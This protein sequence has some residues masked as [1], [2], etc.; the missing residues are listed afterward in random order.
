MKIALSCLN[1]Y[2]CLISFDYYSFVPYYYYCILKNHFNLDIDD[3]DK[4]FRI[5]GQVDTLFKSSTDSANFLSSATNSSYE[6]GNEDWAS[7]SYWAEFF[8]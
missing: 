3:L 5:C 8:H 2:S 6:R 1:H 4:H 7:D